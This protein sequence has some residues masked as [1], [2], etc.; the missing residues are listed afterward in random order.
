M[1]IIISI[2]STFHSINWRIV[3]LPISLSS[4]TNLKTIINTINK[5]N[6]STNPCYNVFSHTLSHPTIIF[7][8]DTIPNPM[9][10]SSFHVTL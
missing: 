9:P 1:P 5:P 4:S 8:Y 3:T 2:L 10:Q 7:I 6:T